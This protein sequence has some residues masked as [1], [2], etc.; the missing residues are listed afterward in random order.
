KTC[1]CKGLILGGS[2]LLAL[3]VGYVDAI[4]YS[5]APASL[6]RMQ[7]VEV[8]PSSRAIMYLYISNLL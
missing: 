7:R 8:V 1:L 5:G 3:A 2:I 4:G 6:K